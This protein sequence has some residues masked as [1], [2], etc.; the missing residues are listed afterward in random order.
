MHTEYQYTISKC[1]VFTRNVRHDGKIRK[2]KIRALPLLNDKCE[3]WFELV[4][5]AERE[6]FEP[7]K[8]LLGH[9]IA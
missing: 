8:H 3:Q 9:L 7:S 1:K 4:A 6:G 5:V 2:A